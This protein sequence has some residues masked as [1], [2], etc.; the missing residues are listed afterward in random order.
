M[1][2]GQSVF[3]HLIYDY[4]CIENLSSANTCIT[5]AC[6]TAKLHLIYLSNY[7]KILRMQDSYI[8]RTLIF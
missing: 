4:P 3:P 8:M 7:I 1:C 6:W 2:K 5:T